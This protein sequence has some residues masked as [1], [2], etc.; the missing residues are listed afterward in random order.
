MRETI[1]KVI[2]V[3]DSI[4]QL[5]KFPIKVQR[6]IGYALY[7]AQRG[8][9]H[10]NAKPIKGFGSGIFEIVEN[11]NS[12]TYRTVYAVQLAHGLYVLHAFQKKSKQGIKTPQK[13]LDLIKDRLKRAKELAYD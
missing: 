3:G 5:K 13:E 12:D 9:L 6:N 2:W 7:F 8:E 1:K 4:K 10:P 11:F